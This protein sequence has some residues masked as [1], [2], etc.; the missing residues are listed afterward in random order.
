MLNLA[1]LCTN[2]SSTLR[3]PMSAVVGMLEGKIP[4]RAPI[5]E[6]S[7]MEQN[8][9]FKA[10]EKLPLDSQTDYS[11]YSHDSQQVGISSDGPW[12][13]SFISLHSAD[14]KQ[15]NVSSSKPLI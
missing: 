7:S 11:L 3:P 1:L 14:D 5:V 13:D 6:R 12:T 2:Q 10:F 8:A 4:V 9:R 15:G